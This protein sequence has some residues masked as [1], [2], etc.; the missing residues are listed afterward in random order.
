MRTR[1][2]ISL[3]RH[4]PSHRGLVHIRAGP[5]EDD[6]AAIHD[7]EFVRKRLGEVEIL[8]DQEDGDLT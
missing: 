5:R 7:V 2:R 4:E 8:L 3:H 1:C 6:L